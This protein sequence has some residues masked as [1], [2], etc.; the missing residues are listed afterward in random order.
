MQKN[1]QLPGGNRNKNRNNKWRPTR[2]RIPDVEYQRSS[3][4]EFIDS[5]PRNPRGKVLKRKPRE[6]YWAGRE[7]RVGTA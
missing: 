7:R 1:G 4:V 6:P 3:S 2:H 5:L